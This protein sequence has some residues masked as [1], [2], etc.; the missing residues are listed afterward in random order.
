VLNPVVLQ[1]PGSEYLLDLWNIVR[2]TRPLPILGNVC[3]ECCPLYVKDIVGRFRKIKIG[4]S[5]PLQNQVPPQVP[6]REYLLDWVCWIIVRSFAILGEEF[7]E[8]CPLCIL[9]T[10]LVYFKKG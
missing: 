6:D 1:V 4:I 7:G 2:K 10:S 8:S 9:K 5:F 3:G